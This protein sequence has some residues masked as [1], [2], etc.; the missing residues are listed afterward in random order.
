MRKNEKKSLLIL[1]CLIIDFGPKGKLNFFSLN[2]LLLIGLGTK[3]KKGIKCFWFGG[4]LDVSDRSPL[5]PRV[6]FTFFTVY[7]PHIPLNFFFIKI[8]HYNLD[9][10]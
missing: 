7:G 9:K 10:Y 2:S 6:E 3:F 1:I 4:D 8:V 5:Y